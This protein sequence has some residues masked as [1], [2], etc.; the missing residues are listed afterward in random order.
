MWPAAGEEDL[1]SLRSAK[2]AALETKT[3]TGSMHGSWWW[4]S[5]ICSGCFNPCH[6]NASKTFPPRP[7]SAP[8]E[9]GSFVQIQMTLTAEVVHGEQPLPHH[10]L[11]PSGSPLGQAALT[12]GLSSLRSDG[13]ESEN[14]T[15][16]STVTFKNSDTKYCHIKIVP[17]VSVRDQHG[18]EWLCLK[19]ACFSDVLWGWGGSSP[20]PSIALPTPQALRSGGH[21]VLQLFSSP[22]A[23]H[24]C[25]YIV[26]NRGDK[27]PE[28]CSSHRLAPEN[29][30]GQCLQA[31][32][33]KIAFLTTYG[34]H[35]SSLIH[36]YW[37]EDVAEPHPSSEE[38][39]WEHT[40]QAVWRT[41][42]KASISWWC[43]LFRHPDRGCWARP[44][45]I[46]VTSL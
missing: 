46:M 7:V 5:A 35:I 41:Q 27:Q 4:N 13:G 34:Q 2:Q 15:Q 44:K 26:K 16:V 33:Q 32:Q 18:P 39:E 30:L 21:C 43:L 9:M 37:R 22:K 24:L 36:F 23:F 38:S 10:C 11:R 17:V 3:R 31:A 12:P 20:C 25:T 14:L 42:T 8:T 29:L 1:G 40:G 28:G 6:W 19:S 45:L